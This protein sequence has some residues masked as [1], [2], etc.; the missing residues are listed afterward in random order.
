MKAFVAA[1]IQD[2][3][4]VAFASKALSPAESRCANIERELLA[5]VYGC[6]RFHNYLFGR[7]FTVESDHKLLASIH[8]K[9]LNTSPARLRRMLMRLQPYDLKIVYQPGAEKY[10]ADTLSQ[11]SGE[12]QDE[13]ADLDVTIHEISSQFTSSFLEEIHTATDEDNELRSLKEI[14]YI[15]WP[16]SRSD[17]HRVLPLYWNFWDELSI[18]NG[19]VTRGT[20]IVIPRKI[21]SRILAQLHLAHQ[22]VEKT[23]LLNVPLSTG[24]GFMMTSSR[25]SRHAVYARRH[26]P[27][28]PRSR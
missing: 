13:I 26:S 21:R 6:E 23:R 5:V 27:S 1:L 3:K 28:N 16:Q 8:L 18:D 17:V 19:I 4:P 7:P 12:D 11:L 22:G 14:I 20:R 10:I 24:L 25:W 15:G 9:H 2:G